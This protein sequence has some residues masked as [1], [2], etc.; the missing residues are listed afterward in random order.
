MNHLNKICLKGLGTGKSIKLPNST[1]MESFVS[2]PNKCNYHT[3][4]NYVFPNSLKLNCQMNQCTY[5]SLANNVSNMYV[6]LNNCRKVV[7]IPTLSLSMMCQRSNYR[8]VDYPLNLVISRGVKTKK[9]AA[10]RF[11]KTGKGDLKYGHA[12][13]RHLTSHKSKD[14]KRRLNSKVVIYA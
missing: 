11:I 14:R 1:M 6:P 13:K 7:T 9:A 4:H 10:K 8:L 5:S 3:Y 2:Q 12:G